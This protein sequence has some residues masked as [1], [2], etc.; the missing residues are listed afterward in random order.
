MSL[1]TGKVKQIIPLRVKTIS[2]TSQIPYSSGFQTLACIRITCKDFKN[3][4]LGPVPR[5]SD[6]EGPGGWGPII[7]IYNP[8]SE[9]V[10][11]CWWTDQA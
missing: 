4:L 3:R 9:Y 10:L 7:C 5:V 11:T 8:K 6:S 2:L 1:A